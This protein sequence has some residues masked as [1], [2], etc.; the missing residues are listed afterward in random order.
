[1]LQSKMTKT[2]NFG[3]A[4]SAI[5]FFGRFP[6]FHLGGGGTLNFGHAKFAIK[7]VRQISN[8]SFPGGEVHL[9]V[10]R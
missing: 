6:T 5:N 7:I 9:Q 3:H 4:K 10:D 1:M 2:S 8:F